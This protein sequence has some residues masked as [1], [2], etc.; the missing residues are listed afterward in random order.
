[1]DTRPVGNH[2]PCR[3]NARGVGRDRRMIFSAAEKVVASNLTIGDWVAA[4]LILLVAILAG[5]VAKAGLFRAVHRGEEDA[6]AALVVVSRILSSVAV[7]VG[8]LYAL[9][10]LGVR[11]GPL[12][13]ALGIGGL[14]IAFAAQSVL[15]NFLA[16]VILQTRR[17]FKR[18]DQ[19]ET[20]DCSGTVED[21]NF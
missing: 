1:R 19:I 3:G 12:V 10:V 14:A 4:G 11:L 7:V 21:V 15:A 17:P 9:G 6:A 2:A 16:S 8:L 18:G 13:G 5:R 20:N